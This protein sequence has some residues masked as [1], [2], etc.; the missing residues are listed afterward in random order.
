MGLD[1]LPILAG[2]PVDFSAVPP[3]LILGFVIRDKVKCEY[4]RITNHLYERIQ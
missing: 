1:D 2:A 3:V 4:S